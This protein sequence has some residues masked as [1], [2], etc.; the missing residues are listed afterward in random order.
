[1][2]Y[3]RKILAS[4]V[5]VMCAATLFAQE[6][7][8]PSLE[9]VVQ[10]TAE[11][12]QELTRELRQTNPGFITALHE[13]GATIRNRQ[14]ITL[15][16]LHSKV[17]E[18]VDG[19]EK[20]TQKSLDQSSEVLAAIHNSTREVI[21]VMRF[22]SDKILAGG[23]TEEEFDSLES[24]HRRLVQHSQALADLHDA[25]MQKMGERTKRISRVFERAQKYGLDRDPTLVLIRDEYESWNPGLTRELTKISTELA[26]ANQRFT[27][28]NW[29]GQYPELAAEFDVAKAAQ[30]SETSEK[31]SAKEPNASSR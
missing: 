6:P 17:A 29:R 8:E 7:Q 9:K 10:D 1:M 26:R 21:E 25:Q 16:E 4:F 22:V 24:L 18:S 14:W 20:L 23:L 28:L 30:K 2:N 19:E 11:S 27:T 5:S 12:L 3:L 15:Y 13:V 31:P